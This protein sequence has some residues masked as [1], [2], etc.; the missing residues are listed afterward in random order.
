[1]HLMEEMRELTWYVRQSESSTNEKVE[2]E[3]PDVLS[4]VLHT[5]NVLKVDAEGAWLRKLE[6]D[7]RRFPITEKIRP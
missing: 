6:K 2:D 4:L 7:E 5:A 3:V 1:M